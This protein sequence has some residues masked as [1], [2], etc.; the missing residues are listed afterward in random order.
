M[1]NILHI[2]Q[3]S[4]HYFTASDDEEELVQNAW[5]DLCMT[6]YMAVE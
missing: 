6:I 5:N 1:H 4:I 3:L 2:L